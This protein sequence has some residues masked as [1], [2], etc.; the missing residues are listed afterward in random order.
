MAPSSPHGRPPPRPDLPASAA[1][2]GA[3]SASPPDLLTALRRITACA[4]RPAQHTA[5]FQTIVQQGSALGAAHGAVATVAENGLLRVQSGTGSLAWLEGEYLPCPGSFVGEAVQARAPRDAMR[6]AGHADAYPLEEEL[7]TGPALAVPLLLDDE[8]L[9]VVLL[10]READERPFTRE[11]IDELTVLAGVSAALV[12]GAVAYDRRRASREFAE[13]AKSARSPKVV[14]LPR[15]TPS[16]LSAA[17]L[18]RALRHEINNPLV[19][20][21][22]HA[23]LLERDP[24][25]RDA[26]PLLSAVQ[27]IAD[28]GR[29]LGELT[30]RLAV[31]E[32][33]PDHAYVTAVGGLGVVPEPKP[34]D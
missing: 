17:E 6:L 13:A 26:Q 28:A 2:R 29:R 25:I 33:H 24:A 3:D 31:A 14:P 22:A 21:R 5:L 27:Q 23:Q 18:I 7:G 4:A 9:G 19:V 16:E 11:E 15:S 30:A 20:V 10:V 32:V 8:A 34:H 1:S 12:A